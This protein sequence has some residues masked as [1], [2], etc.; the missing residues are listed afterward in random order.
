LALNC[1][2]DG[3]TCPDIRV[4]IDEGIVGYDA[5]SC[6]RRTFVPSCLRE[7]KLGSLLGYVQSDRFANADIDAYQIN[8]LPIDYRRQGKRRMRDLETPKIM[9]IRRTETIPVISPE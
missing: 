9:A 4:A 1:G 5:V 3:K 6:P 8:I 7:H 2:N